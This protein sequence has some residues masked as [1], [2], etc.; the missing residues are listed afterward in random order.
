MQNKEL[1]TNYNL[2][3]N[4]KEHLIQTGKEMVSSRITKI[5]FR[6][7]KIV[8]LIK[9]RSHEVFMENYL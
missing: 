1:W 8:V 2:M 4:L 5:R 6:A 7:I 9:L 3:Q